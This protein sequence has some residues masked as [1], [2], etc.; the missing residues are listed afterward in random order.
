M[1]TKYPCHA[2]DPSELRHGLFQPLHLLF[3][4]S[5]SALLLLLHPSRSRRL[6]AVT[7]VTECNG[8]YQQLAARELGVARLLLRIR[9]SSK[10]FCIE[11]LS[12]TEVS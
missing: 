8:D 4:G 3:A 5:R 2:E 10:M 1:A 9:R 11:P 12:G 6:E 7:R